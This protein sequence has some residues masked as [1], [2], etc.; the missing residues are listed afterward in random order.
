MLKA[1]DAYQMFAAST[2]N[3]DSARLMLEYAFSSATEEIIL[4][5][6][7]SGLETI[8]VAALHCDPPLAAALLDKDGPGTS[9]STLKDGTTPLMVAAY[10]NCR[11][12]LS[13]LLG[14]VVRTSLVER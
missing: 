13:L 2:G 4:S 9:L 10:S 7:R 1:Y 12:V 11:P 14:R 3:V 5:H 6:N 8:F